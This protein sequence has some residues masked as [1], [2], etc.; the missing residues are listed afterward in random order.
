MSNKG[1]KSINV[2]EKTSQKGTKYSV[3]EVLLINDKSFSLFLDSAT[4]DLIDSIGVENVVLNYVEKT[5]KE[6]KIYHAIELTLTGEDYSKLFFID[7]A[8]ELIIKKLS[9]KNK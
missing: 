1:I 9:E 4:K 8:Y 6:G 2:V 7:K 3:I 5:N